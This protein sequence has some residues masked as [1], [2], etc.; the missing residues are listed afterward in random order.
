MCSRADI[1]IAVWNEDPSELA[2]ATW[3]FFKDAYERKL[4]CIWISSARCK[5]NVQP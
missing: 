5:M 2:G 4:P 1:A 3:E